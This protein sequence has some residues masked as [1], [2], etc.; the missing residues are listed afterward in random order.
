MAVWEQYWWKH[1]GLVSGP[2][3]IL[4]PQFA[5]VHTTHRFCYYWKE[6]NITSSLKRSF[7]MFLVWTEAAELLL[8]SRSFLGQKQQ[9]YCCFPLLESVLYSSDLHNLYFPNPFMD[10]DISPRRSGF[11]TVPVLTGFVVTKWY[12]DGFYPAVCNTCIISPITGLEWP[13]GS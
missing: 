11:N 3:R 6:Q 2:T 7:K 8:L 9:N 10:W 13:R 4:E 5:A 12:W 1:F